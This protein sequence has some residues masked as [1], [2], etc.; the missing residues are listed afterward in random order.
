MN[1]FSRILLGKNSS[2]KQSMSAIDKGEIKTAFIVDDNNYLLGVITD[3]DIRR[4]LISGTDINEEVSLVMNKNPVKAMKEMTDDEIKS[5]MKEKV[6]SVIPVIDDKN[7]VHDIAVSSIDGNV[8]YI[9]GSLQVPRILK[10][11]LVIGGAGYI[12]SILTRELLGKGYEV[13]VLDRFL[14]VDNSL[15]ALN[16][17]RLMIIRGDTRHIED[18]SEAIQGVD[19]VVNLAE[20]VGDPACAINPQTTI[21]TNFFATTL[22]AQM[23]KR[24]QI[25]RL[26]YM[27]SCSVYGASEKDELLTEESTLNPVSL[28]AKMKIESEK[29]LKY[30]MDSNFKPTIF[31][32][33]TVFGL[34]PRP[35]FDLVVNIFISK[36]IN[37]K[38]IT[39]FGGDQWRPN[40]HAYD[41]SQAIILALEAPLE[42]VGGE[43]FNV[44][45]EDLNYKINDLAAMVSERVSGC[46]L[47]V[48]DKAVDKR[49]YKCSFSK[50]RDKLG[51]IPNKNI[52]DAILEITEAIKSGRIDPDDSRYNNLK[53][54]NNIIT[55]GQ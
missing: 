46:E 14:Y 36:A 47:I 48:E 4:A 38:K 10:K 29:E 20:L 30:L 49:N 19:A 24:H 7:I 26:I 1:K 13:V 32:L 41:V 34:S 6:I 3:G 42:R 54:L 35:R 15:E 8:S 33:G 52:D 25:N 2:I 28:Y 5:L 53:H 11:I 16:N 50:I 23:C 27:S 39:V 12:G 18:I 31:R 40:V 21:D 37:D 17:N 22:V 45:S 51:F 43:V 44:G 55:N 9:K